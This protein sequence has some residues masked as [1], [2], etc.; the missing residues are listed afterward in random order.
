MDSLACLQCLHPKCRGQ[1]Y[2]NVTVL[3][4]RCWVMTGDVTM[5]GLSRWAGQGGSYRTVHR[6][7]ATVI[8]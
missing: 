5:L 3:L 7:F 2:A 6:F 4:W 1:P 8:P